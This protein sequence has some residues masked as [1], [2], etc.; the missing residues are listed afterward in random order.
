M[1]NIGV[2]YFDKLQVIMK[3]T[4]DNALFQI[5]KDTSMIHPYKILRNFTESLRQI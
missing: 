2:L 3:F 5:E 1:L 4:Q